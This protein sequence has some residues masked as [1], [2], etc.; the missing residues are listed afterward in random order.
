M[1]KFIITTLLLLVCQAP[2]VNAINYV[3]TQSEGTQEQ[4]T[5]TMTEA[6]QTEEPANDEQLSQEHIIIQMS[7]DGYVSSH[8][9]HYHF[10]NGN[11]PEDG[12]FSDKL[13][14]P[15]DYIFNETDVVSKVENGAVVSIDGKYYLYYESTEL[16]SALRSEDEVILQAAGLSPQDAKFVHELRQPLGLSEDSAIKVLT[17][18]NLSDLLEEK[19]KQVALVVYPLV[20][21]FV[22]MFEGQLYYLNQQLSPDFTYWDELQA[23]EDAE[24]DLIAIAETGLSLLVTDKGNRLTANSSISHWMTL[25]EYTRGE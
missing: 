18:Q 24:G 2:Q 21:G 19:E 22:A 9:D 15:A 16:A 14:A 6:T 8:G 20:T 11:V 12:V 25:E 1:K 5:N 10:Y 3:T 13:L 23:S 4:D 17:Q 7:A